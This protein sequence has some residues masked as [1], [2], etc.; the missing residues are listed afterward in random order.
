MIDYNLL[1]SVIVTVKIVFPLITILYCVRC[2][3]YTVYC[4]AFTP[5]RRRELPER[6]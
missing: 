3:V 5:I 4:I 2:I 6:L 1:I